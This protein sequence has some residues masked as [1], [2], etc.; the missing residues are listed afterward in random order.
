VIGGAPLRTALAIPSA[1]LDS[2]PP[3]ASPILLAG[4]EAKERLREIVEGFFFRRLTG[5]DGKPVRQLLVRSPPGLG[6]TKEAMEWATRYQTEQAAKESIFD[7]YMDD[8]TGGGV[9]AQVAIFV[10]R[11]ELAHEIKQVIEGNRAALGKP[12][13]VPILRGRDHGA[14]DGKAPCR[15]WREARALGRKGLPIYSNLCRRSQ[16]RQVDQC[17]YFGDCD[18]I[19]A[20]QLP[21]RRR[22]SS[23]CTHTW[24]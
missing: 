14:K 8:I 20:W 5:E 10:P 22:S 2:L 24:A 17:P 13:T 16:E 3:T 4:Q 1:A 12:V 18:Y 15:R 7:L 11:H 23:W 9:R 19:R 6:K 21:M